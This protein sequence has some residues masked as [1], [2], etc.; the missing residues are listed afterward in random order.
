MVTPMVLQMVPTQPMPVRVMAVAMVQ[1]L[2][3]QVPVM[4]PVPW[5]QESLTEVAMMQAPNRSV[6]QAVH[7]VSYATKMATALLT[8]KILFFAVAVIPMIGFLCNVTDKVGACSILKYHPTVAL[9][10][11]NV[12]N[13]VKRP[14]A[15]TASAATTIV[16][17]PAVKIH[18]PVPEAMTVKSSYMPV[19]FLAQAQAMNVPEAGAVLWMTTS[20]L[21]FAH[22]FRIQIV[23]TTCLVQT[24]DH[25]ADAS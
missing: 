14:P 25:R 5:T 18:N 23:S 1:R 21:A 12:G 22:V 11:H 2:W 17:V 16:A 24:Q 10:I 20:N 19:T 4:F 15:L 13:T 6:V 7:T 8:Q 3:M 9:K